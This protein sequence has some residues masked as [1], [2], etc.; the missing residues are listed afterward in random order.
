MSTICF[1]APDRRFAWWFHTALK[2]DRVSHALRCGL[3]FRLL[4]LLPSCLLV[5]GCAMKPPPSTAF[6]YGSPI[7]VLALSKFERVVVEAENVKDLAGLRV[8]GADIFAYVSVGEAE[9]WRA[10][11]SALPRELFMGKTLLGTAASPTLPSPAG[12]TT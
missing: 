1:S 10:T 3:S 7:P 12:A 9:G 5:Y 6:F 8:E 11:S 2:G 4:A